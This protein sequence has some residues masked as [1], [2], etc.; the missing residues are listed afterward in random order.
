MMLFRGP[1]VLSQQA[2][3]KTL[4]VQFTLGKSASC[5]CWVATSSARVRK[6]V[7]P[8]PFANFYH[9]KGRTLGRRERYLIYK[10]RPYDSNLCN[11]VRVRWNTHFC[12]ETSSI[13]TFKASTLVARPGQVQ[14]G[15]KSCQPCKLQVSATCVM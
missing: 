9:G 7:V 14:P 6:E 1:R 10:K 15:A 11:D 2:C 5:G 4:V 12:S 13:N 3:L 8:M